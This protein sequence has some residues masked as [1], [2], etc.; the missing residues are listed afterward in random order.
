[1]K[2]ALMRVLV[3]PHHIHLRD[4]R[5]RAPRRPRRNLLNS[6]DITENGVKLGAHA[7]F[8][9]GGERDAGERRKFFNAFNTD[10]HRKY[11]ST[12]MHTGAWL[13]ESARV[14]YFVPWRTAVASRRVRFCYYN[15]TK[16][17]Y[18]KKRPT[19]LQMWR[20]NRSARIA[21]KST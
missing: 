16:K 13:D 5:A 3:F 17:S 19:S 21:C 18:V 12:L 11:G 15:E 7:L 2:F 8:L 20:Q 6:R 4:D 10:E 14:R 9:L 1:M